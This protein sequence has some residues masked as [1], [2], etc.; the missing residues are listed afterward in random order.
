MDKADLEFVKQL[1]KDTHDGLIAWTRNKKLSGV[2]DETYKAE[3]QKTN[4]AIARIES[5]Y[6]VYLLWLF[7]YEDAKPL[8]SFFTYNVKKN[9]ERAE[10]FVELF[11]AAKTSW[12]RTVNRKRQ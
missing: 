2:L 5:G 3:Y 11:L 4:I 6:T 9:Q 7:D 1:T 10:A 8:H 12:Y